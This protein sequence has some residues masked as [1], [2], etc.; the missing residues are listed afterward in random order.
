MIIGFLLFLVGI[1]RL[2]SNQTAQLTNVIQFSQNLYLISSLNVTWPFSVNAINS[3]VSS[4]SV[5]I[6]FFGPSCYNIF[7]SFGLYDEIIGTLCLLIAIIICL[8]LVGRADSYINNND[9]ETESLS[10]QASVLSFDTDDS[11][12]NKSDRSFN[13]LQAFVLTLSISYAP[14]L[15]LLTK[16]FSCVDSPSGFILVY[17][18]RIKCYD[19]WHIAMRIVSGMFLFIIGIGFPLV[20][21]IILRS[22]KS[23]GKLY[24][25]TS[26]NAFG[27]V[28]LK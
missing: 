16:T 26:K 3:F 20:L 8:Y 6:S 19:T 1:A 14:L 22:I 13:Y 10:K 11:T 17:D 4:A 21:F 2:N 23:D 7:P 27:C 5:S 24:S 9:D 15:T 28:Y 18:A 12:N 25:K